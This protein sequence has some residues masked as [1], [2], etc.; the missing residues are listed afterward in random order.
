[1]IQISGTR[2][3]LQEKMKFITGIY[4]KPIFQQ[5]KIIYYENKNCKHVSG[6]V[7]YNFRST[8]GTEKH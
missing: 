7:Y 1:M 3:G 5:L 4:T 6:F 8:L 2:F